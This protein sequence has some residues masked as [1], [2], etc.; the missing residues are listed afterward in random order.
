MTRIGDSVQLPCKIV[1][2]DNTGAQPVTLFWGR[3]AIFFWGGV[4][5]EQIC[6]PAATEAM[7]GCD[8]KRCFPQFSGSAIYLVTWFCRW[9]HKIT[10]TNVRREPVAVDMSQGVVQ[11]RFRLSLPTP[12][13][14]ASTG[15]R[16]STTSPSL[17]ARSRLS[18][19]VTSLTTE[20]PS[21]GENDGDR[22]FDDFE[23]KAFFV[24]DKT[25]R[26]RNWCITAVMWPYPFLAYVLSA[27]DTKLRYNLV[28]SKRQ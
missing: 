13:T 11:S 21:G 10:A 5:K 20:E 1:S 26:P 7:R 24:L 23:E 15:G 19:E 27:H 25:T 22:G 8:K 6:G 9:R 17:Y 12:L 16:S 2:C 14:P 18:P 28:L 3:Q 4:D